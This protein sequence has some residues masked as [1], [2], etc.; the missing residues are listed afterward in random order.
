MSSTLPDVDAARFPRQRELPGGM[1]SRLVEKIAKRD[2]DLLFPSHGKK[3]VGTP[4]ELVR[5]TMYL[6]GQ[7][8]GL[9][10]ATQSVEERHRLARTQ[11]DEREDP[12]LTAAHPAHL[13]DRGPVPCQVE[14][15]GPGEQQ[16]RAQ[17]QVDA[18]VPEREGRQ[19]RGQV[20]AWPATQV[21]TNSAPAF[22]RISLRRSIEPYQLQ[23]NRSAFA[24]I[25]APACS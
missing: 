8:R 23:T 19:S 6:A 12:H 20:R 4:L 11:M 17:H 1:A 10:I 18:V 3:P 21:A 7:A 22:E 24:Y 14:P 15:V 5:N 16:V 13:Q 25:I 9:Q 2:G